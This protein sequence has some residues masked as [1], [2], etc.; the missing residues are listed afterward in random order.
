MSLLKSLIYF[1]SY[2]T[3]AYLLA[4]SSPTTSSMEC[5]L[6]ELAVKYTDDYLT[7]NTTEV[8]IE[9]VLENV[10]RIAPSRYVPACDQFI[11]EYT[12]ELVKYLTS[13]AD[14]DTICR[15]VKAC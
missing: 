6:C 2:A 4:S 5:D 11:D 15:L 1:V 3:F 14:P 12:P 7:R 9:K 10:C 8:A 13:E